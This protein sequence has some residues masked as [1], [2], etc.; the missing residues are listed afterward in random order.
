MSWMK[1]QTSYE[2]VLLMSVYFYLL[3]RDTLLL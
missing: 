1:G 2:V 3:D